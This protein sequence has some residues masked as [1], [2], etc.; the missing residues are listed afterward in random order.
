MNNI[1]IILLTQEVNKQVDIWE[2]ERTEIIESYDAK[3]K[4]TP[5]LFC[6]KTVG[7]ISGLSFKITNARRKLNAKIDL[8]NKDAEEE[9]NK[10]I[11]IRK[12]L[13]LE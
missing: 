5:T 2:K 12:K 9:R 8:L 1:D 11:E 7:K 3:K 4:I 13:G 10:T 6:R